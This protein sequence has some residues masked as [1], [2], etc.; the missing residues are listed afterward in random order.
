MSKKKKLA[1]I[2]GGVGGVSLGGSA[3]EA[4]EGL[5]DQSVFNNYW[6]KALNVW[7]HDPDLRRIFQTKHDLYVYVYSKM[8]QYLRDAT[9]AFDRAEVLFAVGAVATIGALAAY[10]SYRKEVKNK[11]KETN[12]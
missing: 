5:N 6:N 2:L 4:A 10:K 3:V 9:Q 7:Y 11:E 12:Q 8:G 1:G